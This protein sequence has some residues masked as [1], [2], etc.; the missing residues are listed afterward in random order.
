M[1]RWTFRD[2]ALVTLKLALPAI[3][4][5]ALATTLQLVDASFLGHI[6]TTELAAASL[7]NAYF[8]MVWDFLLGVGTAL[9]TLA[10]QAHGAGDSWSVQRWTEVAA[11]V[12]LALCVPGGL[13][14]CGAAWVAEHAFAQSPAVAALT[15]EYCAGLA[16]GL[17]FFALATCVQKHQ[18]AQS[19]M[20]PSVLVGVVA[21]VANVVFNYVLI[22]GTPLP[23]I[24]LATTT[25]G[26]WAS[27]LVPAG[28]LGFRGSALATSLSRVLSFVLMVAAEALHRS[29]CC[30]VS[31]R[32]GG[33]GAGPEE[34]GKRQAAADVDAG[35]DA[36][37]ALESSTLH[38]AALTASSG[39]PAAVEAM[40]P[41][42]TA[43]VVVGWERRL[44]ELRSFARLGLPGGVMLAL[45][46]WSF[47]VQT[48]LAARLGR[49]ALDAHT[50]MLA[51]ATFCFVS[52]PFGISV[53]A[54]IRVAQLLGAQQPARARV[55]AHA[56]LLLGVLFMTAC[57]VAI[58]LAG[59]RLSALFTPD[60]AVAARVGALAPMVAVFQVV[61]GYQGVASGVL[62]GLGK[63]PFVAWANLFCF[64]VVGVPLGGWLALGPWRLGLGALWG[65]LLVGLVLG[66]GM[67]A[68]ALR[69]TDWRREA[70][71]AYMRATVVWGASPG[72][73]TRPEAAEEQQQR[74]RELRER[75]Q[76]L[77]EEYRGVRFAEPQ[78][79]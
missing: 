13:I 35:A 49:L 65:G 39:H 77:L 72:T 34:V 25:L 54:S 64:W 20:A 60:A 66:C 50:V 58:W 23:P 62:R 45:E 44:A 59:E 10:A 21:N 73:S 12:L 47:E 15:G 4:T 75:N 42:G 9:D 14:L 76:P 68:L 52:F 74:R 22:W 33:R 6:G 26:D 19:R 79:P 57:A 70:Q 51:V 3:A 40:G 55:A 7:G 67:Y 8:R 24:W 53:A 38:E 46:A 69:W 36:A 71:L 16:W 5:N 31:T 43:V 1:P 32:R 63:Q 30:H 56:S 11:V 2:E 48:V 28:G 27:A 41:A 17:P 29:R 18:Q 37:S 61:D 78:P